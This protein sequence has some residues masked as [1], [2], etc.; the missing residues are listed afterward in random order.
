MSYILCTRLL[1]LTILKLPTIHA[2]PC[3]ARDDLNPTVGS[4]P[5]SDSGQVRTHC[6]QF[7]QGNNSLGCAPGLG[8]TESDPR[9]NPNPYPKVVLGFKLCYDSV[10]Q[11]CSLSNCSIYSAHR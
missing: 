2:T 11:L 10:S 7:L 4:T 1:D 6:L 3:T 5:R 8:L 9:E